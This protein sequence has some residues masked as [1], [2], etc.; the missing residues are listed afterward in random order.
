MSADTALILD[1]NLSGRRACRAACISPEPAGQVVHRPCWRRA[2]AAL[3]PRASGPLGGLCL[4]RGL[5]SLGAIEQEPMRSWGSAQRGSP[6]SAGW[7]SFS[8]RSDSTASSRT[9]GRS[10]RSSRA[11]QRVRRAGHQRGATRRTAGVLRGGID[12]AIGATVAYA[13]A[14]QVAPL[15]FDVSPRDPVVYGLVT[16][17]VL[18]VAAAASIVPAWRTARVDPNLALESSE[19]APADLIGDGIPFLREARQRHPP[20][21]GGGQRLQERYGGA[22]VRGATTPR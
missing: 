18:I 2:C 5:T 16:V 6:H 3:L 22:S 15:L 17:A 9:G 8:P 21:S 14:C 13:V 10:A 19:S 12:A 7:R 4:A 1:R 20:S 11:Y